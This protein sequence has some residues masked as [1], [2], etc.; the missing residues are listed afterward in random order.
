MV[1]RQCNDPHNTLMSALPNQ[2]LRPSQAPTPSSVPQTLAAEQRS[3]YSQIRP[4]HLHSKGHPQLAQLKT[5]IA[6]KSAVLCC[7]HAILSDLCCHCS[8]FLRHACTCALPPR[9]LRSSDTGAACSC[10]AARRPGWLS[11]APSSASRASCCCALPVTVR[12]TQQV[13][14]SAETCCCMATCSLL[15]VRTE[16]G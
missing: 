13:S 7:R 5:P 12:I 14:A 3:A 10:R 8:H 15:D 11:P 4:R 9:C 2:T 1:C 16:L 6:D